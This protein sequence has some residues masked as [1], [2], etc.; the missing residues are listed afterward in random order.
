MK[1]D[2]NP[3]FSPALIASVGVALFALLG[4]GLLILRQRQVP[5]RW[6]YLLAGMRIGIILLFLVCLLRPSFVWKRT[7]DQGPALLV[8]LDASRSM[9]TADAPDGKTR[10]Q[11]TAAWMEK[12]GLGDKLAKGNQVYWFR[13]DQHAYQIKREELGATKPMIQT[14]R[15]AEALTSAWEQYRYSAGEEAGSA[16]VVLASDGNDRSQKDVVELARSLGIAIDTL[17]PH[18][19]ESARDGAG[20]ASIVSIQSPRRVLLGSESR[21]LV[22][23]RHHGLANRLLTLSLKQNGEVV[24]SRDVQF[25]SEEHEQQASLVYRPAKSGFR[26]YEIVLEGFPGTAPSR[27][28]TVEVVGN[29]HEVLMIENTWR[30]EFKYLRRIL[31]DDPS[32]SFTGFLSRGG[33]TYV[34]F[35]DA[36]RQNQLAAFPRGGDLNLFDIIVLGDVDPRGWAPGL[37]ESIY[38]LVVNKGKSLIV[39]AGPHLNS[40]ASVPEME[41]LLPV[42]LTPKSGEPQAGPVKVQV[43]PALAQS[44][45]FFNA[46]PK[47]WADLPAM[48][49]IYLV[50]HKKPAAT[51]LLEAPQL[52]NNYGPLIVAAEHAAGKGRV[53][54]I[55]TDTLWKWQMSGTEAQPG[56]TPYTLFW[57]QTLRA[58]APARPAAGGNH[59]WL[60]LEKTAYEV[61]EEIILRAQLDVPP[62]LTESR[63]QLRGSVKLPD[64]RELPISFTPDPKKQRSFT[65]KLDASQPGSYLFMAEWIKEGG[66]VATSQ[67]A[68]D[69]A[70]TPDE[71]GA[72]VNQNNLSRIAASTGGRIIDRL[73]RN[74]WP[75]PE[76]LDKK[77]VT[78]TITASL[79]DNS[80]LLVL[81]VLLMGSDWAIRLKKGLI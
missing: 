15:Y 47:A 71:T 64:Q 22:M 49:Q 12:S 44:S 60:Q 70:H 68:V 32:F 17:A 74:T 36:D 80:T 37:T 72:S 41:A 9:A 55:G 50:S 2:W 31:G 25:A 58:L 8:L 66:V 77:P 5:A 51:I 1:V 23:L 19:V 14:S 59:L 73:D 63:P 21:F 81:L 69:V 28:M 43:P 45:F 65:A 27:K 10:F 7:T 42:A 11:E 67:T 35:A 54:F 3:L 24:A 57:Q 79:W 48:D 13:F 46:G 61:G 20:N 29:R 62:S 78:R 75:N 56:V 53:L 30:W 33:Q 52:K 39:L 76:K 26:E 4:W 16:R 34:A 40:L 18:T 38:D 6:I